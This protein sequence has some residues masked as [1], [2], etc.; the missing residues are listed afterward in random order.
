MASY[1]QNYKHDCDIINAVQQYPELWY[2]NQFEF[3][4]AVLAWE[5]IANQLQ[6]D[7]KCVN[8]CFCIDVHFK[9]CYYISVDFI[10]QRWIHLKECFF[11]NVTLMRRDP[12]ALSGFK[13]FK[14]MLFLCTSGQKDS[15]SKTMG[16]SSLKTERSATI[17]DE[18]IEF[19]I[20]Q[21][22]IDAFEDDEEDIFVELSEEELDS[23]VQHHDVS[24]EVSLSTST[25]NENA[26]VTAP[27]VIVP[28]Q[29][30]RKE[31]S[32]AEVDISAVH[33]DQQTVSAVLEPPTK[34]MKVNLNEPLLNPV[35]A[36]VSK[37]EHRC[38]D[39]IFGEL[40]AAMLQKMENT[41][42]K[43]AKRKIMDI[44]LDC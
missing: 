17:A 32:V 44:L 41:N 35:V 38:E 13:H 30:R 33:S 10:K 8:G 42:K 24:D 9:N 29:K 7:G 28:T 12:K 6:I 31:V 43:S 22:D 19:S 26:E 25:N 16:A 40:V 15:I 23:T 18:N 27:S 39:S 14:N 1:T 5:E 2:K 36:S 3:G 20:T 37:S 21:D 34:Q 11:R 4:D